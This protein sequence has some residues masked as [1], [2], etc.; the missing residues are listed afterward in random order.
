MEKL[1]RLS[2]HSQPIA[3]APLALVLLADEARMKFPEYW[4]QDMGAAAE[5]ILLE[6]A[7]LDLGAVWLGVAPL[8]ERMNYLAEMFDLNGRIKPFAVIAIGYPDERKNTF[9]DR[10]NPSAIHYE[11]Y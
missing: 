4:Q 3:K 1:S 6:A 7:D 11:S 2:P 8:A 5:N 10:Y 9:I